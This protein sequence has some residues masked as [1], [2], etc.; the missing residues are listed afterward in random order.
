MIF[1]IRDYLKTQISPHSVK[2]SVIIF[3][4]DYLSFN[5]KG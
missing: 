4:K 5:S 1:L 2:V 3:S